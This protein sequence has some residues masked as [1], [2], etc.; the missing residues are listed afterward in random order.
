MQGC[1]D[2]KMQFPRETSVVRPYS[3]SVSVGKAELLNAS[4]PLEHIGNWQ[5]KSSYD[6]ICPNSFY[7]HLKQYGTVK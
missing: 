7:L 2:S 1:A 4:S 5:F 6:A 3:V